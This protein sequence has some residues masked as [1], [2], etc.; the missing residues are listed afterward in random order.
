MSDPQPDRLKPRPRR[1]DPLQPDR[2]GSG[3]D[4]TEAP[5]PAAA[6]AAESA[7]SAQRQKKQSEDALDNVSKGYD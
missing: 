3:Q 5:D 4:Q 2:P 1:A 6:D 7:D